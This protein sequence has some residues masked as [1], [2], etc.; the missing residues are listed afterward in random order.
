MTG[1]CH[2]AWFMQNWG[3]NPGFQQARQKLYQL[4]YILS[5]IQV[6]I[7]HLLYARPWWSR[8]SQEWGVYM[9]RKH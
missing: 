5:L 9:S 2:H 7:E 8:L 6:F 1:K 3:W 4:S